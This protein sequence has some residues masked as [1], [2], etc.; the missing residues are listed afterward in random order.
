MQSTEPSVLFTYN[1][2][3]LTKIFHRLMEI[4]GFATAFS[5]KVAYVVCTM[6]KN[7]ICKF[8]SINWST[9]G[10]FIRASQRRI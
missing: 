1:I 5:N 8:E 7:A 4:T 2:G 3:I 9:V 6:S 10:I